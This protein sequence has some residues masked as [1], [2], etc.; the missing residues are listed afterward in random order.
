MAEIRT[1]SETIEEQ[2]ISDTYTSLV[3]NDQ[4]LG[5]QVIRQAEIFDQQAQTKFSHLSLIMARAQIGQ[6]LNKSYQLPMYTT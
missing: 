2:L 5:R 4:Q 6:L 1:A 3:K